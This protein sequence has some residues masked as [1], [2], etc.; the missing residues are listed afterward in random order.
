LMIEA[1]SFLFCFSCFRRKNRIKRIAESVLKRPNIKNS[2]IVNQKSS[3]P[4]KSVSLP[5]QTQK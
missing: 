3:I 1:L 4:N 2:K 5:L